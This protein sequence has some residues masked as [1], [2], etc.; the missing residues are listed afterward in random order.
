MAASLLYRF[1][2]QLLSKKI[3][4][5]KSLITIR[6]ITPVFADERGS[7]TDIL[8]VELH[9]IGHIT[10]TPGAVRA[11]HYH[12]KSVQYDYVLAGQIRLIVCRP[13]GTDR[14]EYALG[15]GSLTE[16]P[17]GVVH[18]YV[19]LTDSVMLDMTT[20]SREADGYEQDTVRVEIEIN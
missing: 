11:K 20:L 9:H 3:I 13:D 8:N 6:T 7:I 1:R 15:A 2:I 16:I 19:G 10:F 5:E 18:T 14:E 4:M 12:K 17:P